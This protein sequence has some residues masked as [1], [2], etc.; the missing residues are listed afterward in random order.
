MSTTRDELVNAAAHVFARDG[1]AR[2]TV[3][4]VCDLAGVTKGALYGHFTS[5]AELAVAVVEQDAVELER[6]RERLQWRHADPLQV[7][8]DLGHLVHGGDRVAGRLVYRAPVC[9]EVAGEL[10]AWWTRTARDLLLSASY[11]G[12]LHA[13]VDLDRAA[14]GVVTSLVGT[15]LMAQ[16]TGSGAEER[17]AAVWRDWLPRVAPAETVRR[18]RLTAPR[19][20][21]R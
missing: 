1:Y 11:R 21:R 16:A 15:Q 17:V 14:R 8:V 13:G 12:Q 6:A 2:A 4:R 9:D 10:V 7:L 19:P 20:D 5:K 18:L 3:D